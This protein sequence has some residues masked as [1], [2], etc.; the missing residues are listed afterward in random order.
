MA[1]KLKVCDYCGS[2]HI[3]TQA[4]VDVNTNEYIERVYDTDEAENAY[5]CSDC[6]SGFTKPKEKEFESLKNVEVV[7]FQVVDEN[8]DIHPEMSGSWVVYS[9][10]QAFSMAVEE[11]KKWKILP[12]YKGDIEDG[13]K[14][15][16]G[17]PYRPTS[18][19][20][21]WNL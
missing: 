15:F 9:M 14:N 5:F 18:E 8:N 20:G 6:E 13:K 17:N 12:I 3:Q 19:E 21:Y 7:G 10:R 16:K 1:I 4:W 11:P 2:T